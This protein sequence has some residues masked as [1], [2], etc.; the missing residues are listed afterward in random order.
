MVRQGVGTLAARLSAGLP[1]SIGMNVSRISS[2]AQ[3]R[4]SVHTNRGEIVARSVIVTASIGVLQAGSIGFEPGLTPEFQN[5]LAALTM[6]STIKIA[7]AFS[8]TSPAL[9][10]GAN[11]TLLSRNEDQRGAEFLMRPFAAPLA[12][13]T[14]GGALALDLESR[15]AKDHREFAME[16]L[17]ALIGTKADRGLRGTVATSWGR[18]PLVLG[19]VSAARPGGWNARETLQQ[20]IAERVFLAGEAFGGKAVQTVHGAYYSG[21]AA[22]RRVLS[23]LKRKK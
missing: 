19:S 23:L 13:C 14:A 20:P 7:M 6:G 18:N 10:F 4:V 15:T 8:D 17:R 22:G 2:G 9:R 1:I 16:S 5:A 3:G 21:Q 11:S 12:I